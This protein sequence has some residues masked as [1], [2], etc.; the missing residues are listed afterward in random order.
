MNDETS[1]PLKKRRI[2]IKKPELN[3]LEPT[4][5]GLFTPFQKGSRLFG[6]GIFGVLGSGGNSGSLNH[7]KSTGIKHELSLMEQLEEMKKEFKKNFP[8]EVERLK[9]AI[10]QV[11]LNLKCL[12][13]EVSENRETVRKIL[14]FRGRKRAIGTKIKVS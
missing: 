11:T 13:N 9:Q 8:K 12:C 7:S 1:N 14:Q 10:S 2:D 3:V 5:S 4:C 6:S